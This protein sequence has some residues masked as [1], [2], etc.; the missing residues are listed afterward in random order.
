MYQ[1]D[2]QNYRILFAGLVTSIILFVFTFNYEIE[3]EKLR[4]ESVADIQFNTISNMFNTIERSNN[5][6]N[7]RFYLIEEINNED[8]KFYTSTLI[9]QNDFIDRILFAINIPASEKQAYEME[10]RNEGYTG[11]SI[12]PFPQKRFSTAASDNFLLPVKYIEPFN[13]KNSMLFG[14]NLYTHPALASIAHNKKQ[15]Q[16]IQADNPGFYAINVLYHGYADA[17]PRKDFSDIYGV[18]VYKI[19][20]HQQLPQHLTRFTI[21]SNNTPIFENR[22]PAA[23]TLKITSLFQKTIMEKERAITTELVFSK[24]LSEISYTYPLLALLA[25]LLLTVLI[26][27]IITS[28]Q[29]INQLLH[30]QKSLVEQEVEA[31]TRELV[32]KANELET[33]LQEQVALTDELEAFSY[34][35]SHDLKAPLHGIDGFSQLLHDCYADTLDEQ[36]LDYI[37]HINIASKKMAKIIKD[38]LALAHISRTTIITSHTNISEIAE[39]SIDTIR[40]YHLN[41]HIDVDICPD[42]YANVDPD[43]IEICFD[44][45]FS[46]A[47][48]YS[49][50]VEHPRIEFAKT[51]R[52]GQTVYYVRD[53]GVGFSMQEASK[54]F[55]PFQ[56]L[57]PDSEFEGTGIGLMTVQRIIRKHN[58]EIWAESTPGKGATFFFTLN[59]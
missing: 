54:L 34:S 32:K 41:Q 13:V 18:L 7:S 46:N 24:P 38:L 25:G 3:K 17:K 47:W 5:E 35:V 15:L 16:Y 12:R 28:Q 50:K 49:S 39:R 30:Q 51:E 1:F 26:Q 56:R 58:G 22:N 6:L 55:V 20:I 43:F 11:F 40:E 42:L 23:G 8:F 2:K 53:N 29:S 36:A 27:K 9:K 59:A 57:H 48:K 52:D 37:A 21:K 4:F 10:L 44:N 33:A 31:K 14:V 19:R 45:L